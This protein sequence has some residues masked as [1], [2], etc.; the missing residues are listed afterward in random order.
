MVVF[1]SPLYYH[2][3]SAQIKTAIDRFHGIDDDLVGTDK[4]AMLLMMAAS[5]ILLRMDWFIKAIS[6]AMK[7]MQK[8]T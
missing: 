5:T 7:R 4:K 1:V 3:L 8:A 6:T 2:G